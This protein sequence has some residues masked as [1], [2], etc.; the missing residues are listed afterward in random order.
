M[1]P[2]SRATVIQVSPPKK[3][4]KKGECLL[5]GHTDVNA[6]ERLGGKCYRV[7][8]VP[9]KGGKKSKGIKSLNVIFVIIA[10]AV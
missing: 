8:R 1:Y 2:A 3:S 6:V 7:N 10:L 5:F 4:K 9:E